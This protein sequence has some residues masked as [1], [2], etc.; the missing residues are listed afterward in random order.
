VPVQLLCQLVRPVDAHPRSVALAEPARSL[1]P[2]P[3]AQTADPIAWAQATAVPAA[4][5][6]PH[7]NLMGRHTLIISPRIWS[8]LRP[9]GAAHIVEHG[10]ALLIDKAG[11]QLLRIPEDQRPSKDLCGC[12]Q[13]AEA[14]DEL[15][16]HEQ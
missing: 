5:G 3:L 8:G 9:V 14:G 2:T 16:T 15:A 7:A 4:P 1:R 6:R 13:C 10:L 11:E 12:V